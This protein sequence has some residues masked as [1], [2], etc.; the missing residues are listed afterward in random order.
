MELSL[1]RDS[2]RDGRPVYRQIADHFLA[3]IECGRLAAGARL[4]AIRDL[5]RSLEVNRDTVAL[6]YDA[7]TGAG[8]AESTVG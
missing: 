5:A 8:A 1:E 4:P 2:L 7:L 6:A 3:E